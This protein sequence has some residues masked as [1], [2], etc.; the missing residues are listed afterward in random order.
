MDFLDEL[1]H[2]I[3]PADGA[4]GTALMDA[5]VPP[6]VCF[7]ELCV[8]RPEAVSAVHGQA[9]AAG[10]RLLRTNSF[11]AN[12]LR[13]A[14]HGQERR[15][16]ELNWS[17]AQLAQAAARGTGVHVAGSVG[18]LGI[19]AAEAQARGIDRQEVF[20]EQIG[21]LLDGGARVIFLETFLDLDELLLAVQVKHAL[22]HC[23]VIASL[24]CPD[25]G[26]LP[27]AT[28]LAEA[29]A[30]L[31]AAEADVVGINGVNGPAVAVRLLAGFTGAGPLAA[32]PNAG[33][34]VR[35]VYP[36]TP[37]EFAQAAGALA[38][39]GVRLFGGGCGTTP[40]HIATI[41]EALAILAK[42]N[43]PRAPSES[44]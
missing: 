27:D 15:V 18:P 5:G 40:A 30:K 42:E 43:V 41:A 12:A 38:A 28:P 39:R 16:S 8:S 11:G 7:E 20:T 10:A 9:I 32:L 14:R 44:C 34:P 19:S 29:L 24:A 2:R 25:H 21:A 22:H 13:L 37:R 3:L 33:L 1:Q 31:R 4:M 17:A 6:G 23:P 35:G 36:A 26:R